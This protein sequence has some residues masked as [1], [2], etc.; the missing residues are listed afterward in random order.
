MATLDPSLSVNLR[1]QVLAQ[2]RSEIVSGRSAPGT[3]YTVPTVAGEL[4]VSTTPVREAL[5]ELSRNGLVSPL[6]NRGFRV[7]ATSL[8]D[9]ENLF[10]LRVLLEKNALVTLARRGLTDTAPLV[11]LADAVRDAVRAGDVGA[12]VETDR[13]FH[14]ALVARADNPKLTKL[15]MNLRDDMRLYGID[16]TEG[17]KRQKASVAEHYQMI[18]LGVAGD[19]EGIG[20]LITRHIE[21]WKPLFTA[22][23]QKVG[24]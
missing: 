3:I 4:G 15:V 19:T 9:L 17:R 14:E 11:A 16:S 7:E 10:D 6:R 20:A 5:L 13:R 22:A 24:G 8:Q 23:L 12:Y 18:E 1:E 21:E 2:L